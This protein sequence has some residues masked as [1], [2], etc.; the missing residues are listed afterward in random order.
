MGEAKSEESKGSL[1]ILFNHF[2]NRPLARFRQA[3]D[4]VEQGNLDTRLPALKK[5]EIG[6]L[7]GHFNTMVDNLN[8][9]K[10][11]IAEILQAAEAREAQKAKTEKKGS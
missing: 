10:K 1:S 9:S 5:D 6:I 7:E 4:Q 8:N 3:L 11:K 2:I